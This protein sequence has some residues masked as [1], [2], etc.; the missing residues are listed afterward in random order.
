[1]AA[2]AIAIAA[3]AL[4]TQV[5]QASDSRPVAWRDVA[6]GLGPVVWP[7]SATRSF[8]KRSQLLD[9]LRTT[10]PLGG[11]EPPRIDF[12]RRRLV[13]IAAGPRSST[14]YG[15]VVLGVRERRGSVLVRVRET[16]PSLG[17]QVVPRLTSPYRLI[18]I[19]ATGKP[20]YVQWQGRP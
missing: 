10:F 18:T 12:A 8:W 9:Y 14:G 17:Q 19:P 16:T 11:P 13:L 5:V 1:V 3:G 4:W 20:V 6:P 7:R 15:V 2:V